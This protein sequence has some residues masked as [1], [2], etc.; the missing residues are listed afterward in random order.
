MIHPLLDISDGPGRA[1]GGRW[2]QGVTLGFLSTCHQNCTSPHNWLT[3]LPLE[4]VH[5]I[6]NIMCIGQKMS[7]PTREVADKNLLGHVDI[8]LAPSNRATINVTTWVRSDGPTNRW[9]QLY[10]NFWTAMTIILK[11][12]QLCLI[13]HLFNFSY[14]CTVYSHTCTVH[15]G[16]IPRQ[17]QTM[18]KTMAPFNKTRPKTMN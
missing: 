7:L 1:G 17:N 9:L 18:V 14:T 15:T 11:L 12:H 3:S 2:Y 10:D 8:Q 6:L 13:F 16:C 4:K 5:I